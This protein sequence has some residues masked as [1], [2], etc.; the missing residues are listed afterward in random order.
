[1]TRSGALQIGMSKW[2]LD[3]PALLMDLD[4]MERNISEMARFTRS[5]GVGL[6]PHIKN[7]MS[8]FI[9]RKQLEAGAAGFCCQTITEAEIVA[10]WG[11]RDILITNEVVGRAKIRRLIGLRSYTNVMVVVDDVANAGELSEAALASGRSLDVFIDVDTGYH[12]CGVMP[13]EPALRFAQGLIGLKGLHLKGINGYSPMHETDPKA[14]R[15]K[16]ELMLNASVGTRTMLQEKGIPVDILSAGCTSVYDI[17]A[18]YPGVTEIQPGTYALMDLNNK[19]IVGTT[20]AD[21]NYSLTVLA[22]VI[23]RPTDDRIVVDAGN[24][25]LA[26]EH[27]L[28][29]PKG[30]DGAELFRL[31]AEHS[32]IR[33]EGPSRKLKVGDMIELL[34]SYCDGTVNRWSKFLGIRGDRLEAILDI[35]RCY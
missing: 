23:S 27:C 35:H 30:V 33:A 34:V 8:P 18:T 17:A 31:S 11:I 29:I 14:R 15:E 2:D 19:E 22:T 26:V 1:M 21:L 20:P 16:Q 9:A 24:K 3:T 12:R 28:P 4:V 6:R 5:A 25:T 32:R 13:F 7:H 10:S